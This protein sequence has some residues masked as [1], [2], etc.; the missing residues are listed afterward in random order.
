M[1]DEATSLTLLVRAVLAAGL[2]WLSRRELVRLFGRLRRTERSAPT[3]VVRLDIA[4][5]WAVVFAVGAFLL[6]CLAFL[7]IPD[8]PLW[9]FAGL[10]TVALAAVLI[11][12]LLSIVLGW[13]EGGERIRRSRSD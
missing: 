8:P 9:L 10:A 12:L 1:T 13:I 6:L 11:G 4:R 5:A 3:T 2:L 7:L